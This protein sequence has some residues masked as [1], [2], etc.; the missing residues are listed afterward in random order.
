VVLAVDCELVGCEP[1]VK[2]GRATSLAHLHLDNSRDVGEEVVEG[3]V[4]LLS[5]V[6]LNVWNEKGVGE[7]AVYRDGS[8][9]ICSGPSRGLW[10]TVI[11]V[12]EALPCVWYNDTV[13]GPARFSLAALPAERDCVGLAFLG[14][15]LLPCRGPVPESGP[16]AVASWLSAPVLALGKWQ[17]GRCR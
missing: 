8:T 2:K 5:L 11:M 10:T 14:R 16:G 6:R 3:F 1:Y 15:G 17:E 12:D 7:R 4:P 9:F 13:P